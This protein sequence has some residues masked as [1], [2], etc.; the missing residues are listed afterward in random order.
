[1]DFCEYDWLALAPTAWK[2]PDHSASEIAM[3]RPSYKKKTVGIKLLNRAINDGI[4]WIA[5]TNFLKVI[6]IR[7]FD[8]K[9]NEKVQRKN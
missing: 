6:K 3:S 5:I 9:K 7:D 1:M 8:R 2:S 4:F